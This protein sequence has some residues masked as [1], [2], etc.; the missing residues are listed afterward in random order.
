MKFSLGAYETLQ[1]TTIIYGLA[2]A[3]FGANTA[4]QTIPT[5]NWYKGPLKFRIIRACI[6]NIAII[7]SWIIVVYQRD[8]RNKT[9]SVLVGFENYLINA[10]HFLLL[11]YILFGALP[12]Y[13]FRKAKLIKLEFKISEFIPQKII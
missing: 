3:L 2:G 4:F 7:P 13:L 12:A 1:E 11:Y 10:A 5:L 8:F 6:A 9:A